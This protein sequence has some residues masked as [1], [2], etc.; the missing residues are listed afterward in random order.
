MKRTDRD[1][2][3]SIQAAIAY[4]KSKSLNLEEYCN[5]LGYSKADTINF[6]EWAKKEG[7]AYDDATKGNWDFCYEKFKKGETELFGKK[8]EE[9]T[10]S[11][12]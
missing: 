12:R 11:F 5:T 2:F 9:K 3:G 1:E 10:D 7:F 6:E 4:E 8:K